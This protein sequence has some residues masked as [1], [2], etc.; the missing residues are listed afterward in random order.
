[1]RA[2]LS[3]SGKGEWENFTNT[4]CVAEELSV[5]ASLDGDTLKNVVGCDS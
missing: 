4:G 1:M 3:F 5:V 2:L